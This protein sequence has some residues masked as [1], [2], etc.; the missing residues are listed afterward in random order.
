MELFL[1]FLCNLFLVVGWEICRVLELELFDDFVFDVLC[2]QMLHV[3]N[4]CLHSV[5]N[6]YIHGEMAW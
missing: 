1:S 2:T 5:K 6:G 4:I 3:W